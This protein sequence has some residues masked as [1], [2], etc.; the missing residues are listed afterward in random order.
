MEAGFVG[1]G[2][3]GTWFLWEDVII[4]FEQFCG[5]SET[6]RETLG[7]RTRRR[8]TCPVDRELV[9]EESSLLGEGHLWGEDIMVESLGPCEVQRC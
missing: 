2:G 7:V 3:W 9:G 5:L 4:L 6:E 8:A 1:P